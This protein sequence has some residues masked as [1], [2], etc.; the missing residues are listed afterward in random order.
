MVED[1]LGERMRK[2]GSRG[3]LDVKTTLVMWEIIEG[4]VFA[5]RTEP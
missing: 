3:S 1:L 4:I 5:A 2:V